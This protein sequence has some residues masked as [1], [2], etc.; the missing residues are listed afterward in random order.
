MRFRKLADF[1]PNFIGPILNGDK[2]QTKEVNSQE[3][4]KNDITWL[5]F[6]W[7]IRDSDFNVL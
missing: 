5:P 4:L 2:P 1:P 3:T 6:V 7:E